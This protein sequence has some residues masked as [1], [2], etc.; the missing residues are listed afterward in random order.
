MGPTWDPHGSCPQVGPMLTPWTLLSGTYDISLNVGLTSS[1]TGILVFLQTTVSFVPIKLSCAWIIQS[2]RGNPVSIIHE[3]ADE[4]CLLSMETRRDSTFEN[5]N[6]Q[7]WNQVSRIQMKEMKR[8]IMWQMY[9]IRK[10]VDIT[11][12]KKVLFWFNSK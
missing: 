4:V 2:H 9:V 10:T 6:I 7:E 8:I 1:L 12:R 3:A 11:W 5:I